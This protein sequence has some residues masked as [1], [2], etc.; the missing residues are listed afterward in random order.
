MSALPYH[1]RQE[2]REVYLKKYFHD[3]NDVSISVMLL[4]IILSQSVKCYLCSKLRVANC[5]HR[6][7][8]NVGS[9]ESQH[10]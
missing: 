7:T 2:H 8:T 10:M 1:V 4:S 6:A 9:W 3:G 5:V